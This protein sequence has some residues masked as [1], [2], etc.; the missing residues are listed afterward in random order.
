MTPERWPQI[1][2]VL[3]KALELAPAGRSAYLNQ[4]C[5][6][7]LS[8]RQEVETLLASSDDVRSSFLQSVRLRVPLTSGTK[9]GES[10]LAIVRQRWTDLVEPSFF[11][12]CS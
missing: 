1:Q 8:L 6:S 4:A 2:D 12:V 9:L 7:D 5:S 10:T 3:Q 11:R